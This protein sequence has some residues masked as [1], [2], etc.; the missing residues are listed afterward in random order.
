MEKDIL[1][2]GSLV[3]YKGKPAKI[4]HLDDKLEIELASKEKLKVRP[5]DIIL[6]HSGP[7]S[8]LNNLSFLE[9]DIETALEIIGDCSITLK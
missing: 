1:F 6:I 3:E 4:L 7:I 9:T 5:K 2:L 8:S